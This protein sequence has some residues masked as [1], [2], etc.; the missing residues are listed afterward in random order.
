M[1]YHT[2]PCS[3]NHTVNRITDNSRRYMTF[4][5]PPV[6]WPHLV[7]TNLVG[8]DR[9]RERAVLHCFPKTVGATAGDVFETPQSE[10]CEEDHRSDG[11][12]R[13]LEERLPR[14][15]VDR[16]CR[17]FV[18]RS[19]RCYAAAAASSPAGS[20]SRYGLPVR[21]YLNTLVFRSRASVYRLSELFILIYWRDDLRFSSAVH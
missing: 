5:F 16:T 11:E 20:S 18:H 19:L 14:R 1:L 15:R 13:A 10:S 8:P 17:G 7:Q 21:K 9:L 6:K 3:I 2:W 12:P 4:I